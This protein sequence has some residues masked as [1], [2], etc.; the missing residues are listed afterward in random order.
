MELNGIYIVDFMFFNQ[1]ETCD[2]F[3][4]Y[5]DFSKKHGDLMEFHQQL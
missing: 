1:V 3:V 5:W 2:L 4:I